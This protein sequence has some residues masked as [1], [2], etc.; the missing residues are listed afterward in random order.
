MNVYIILLLH[1]LHVLQD[2]P[3]YLQDKRREVVRQ[4]REHDLKTEPVVRIFEMEDVKEQ[5]YISHNYDKCLKSFNQIIFM[6]VK[7]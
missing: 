7:Q 2:V 4:L 1:H 5:V 6:H 3:E